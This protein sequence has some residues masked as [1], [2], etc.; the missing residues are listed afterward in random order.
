MTLIDD[1]PWF[2]ARDVCAILFGTGRDR[3]AGVAQ[4]LQSLD[5]AEKVVLKRDRLVS[6]KLVDANQV[7]SATLTLISESGLYKLVMRSD[8]P[9]AKEFQNWIT[10]VVL[11]AIRKDGG[12]VLGEAGK[13][14]KLVHTTRRPIKIM[15]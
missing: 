10:K 3:V 5:V 4:R 15:Q 14:T 6:I 9:Q 7:G 12:Y 13:G 1:Q 8:K 11:P 2:V